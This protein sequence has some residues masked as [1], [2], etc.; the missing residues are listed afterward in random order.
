[1][2]GSGNFRQGEGIWKESGTEGNV[3]HLKNYKEAR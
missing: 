2:V 1:M 3:A